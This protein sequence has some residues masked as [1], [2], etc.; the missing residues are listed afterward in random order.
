MREE[1]LIG[2]PGFLQTI[3]I[4]VGHDDLFRHGVSANPIPPESRGFRERVHGAQDE[5]RRRI[6]ERIIP[7]EVHDAEGQP[8][9]TSLAIG[10]VFGRHA[11]G[12]IDFP[13]IKTVVHQHAFVRRR[14]PTQPIG[15]WHVG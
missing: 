9:A 11:P 14:P 15:R 6:E 10:E 5:R 13:H 2:V 8:R 4:A 1:I 3:Q 12:G 7:I